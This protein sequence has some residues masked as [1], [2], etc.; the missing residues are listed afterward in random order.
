MRS[1]E[2]VKGMKEEELHSLFVNSDAFIGE[3]ISTDV[4]SVLTNLLGKYPELS[5]KELFL[6]P[7]KIGRASCRERV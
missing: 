3:W 7:A 1:G 4:D 2:Q 5:H 6:I